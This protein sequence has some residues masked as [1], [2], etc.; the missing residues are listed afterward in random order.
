MGSDVELTIYD[1]QNKKINLIKIILDSVRFDQERLQID[2]KKN[3]DKF[4][5]RKNK[6]I[7][8][9]DLTVL[10]E[11]LIFQTET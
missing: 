8:S 7:N 9:A 3:D 6:I 4:N 2:I 10:A 5:N 1:R 11:S